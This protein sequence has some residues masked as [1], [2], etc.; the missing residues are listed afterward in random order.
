ME[1]SFL[2]Y[3]FMPSNPEG[4]VFTVELCIEKGAENQEIWFPNW[5]PGSYKIR[6]FSKHII[7]VS[8]TANAKAVKLKQLSKSVWRVESPPAKLVVTAK[9]YGWDISVRGCH[10]DQTHGFFNGTHAF[11]AVKGQ[12]NAPCTVEIT[13]PEAKTYQDWTLATGM[14][15]VK[16]DKKG[17]GLY[18]AQNYDELIDHPFEMSELDV[19]DFKPEGIPHKLALTGQIEN[20]DR[21]KIASDLEKLCATQ[22]KLF[23]E[24]PSKNYVF[25]C[26]VMG[27]AF[28]GLEHRASSK[29]VISRKNIPYVGMPDDT[30]DYATF[31]S[32]VSHEYF[33]TWNVKRI[34]PEIFMP[35][36]L[37]SESYTRQLWI[38][39][40]FTSYYE[41]LLLVR[42]GVISPERF[43]SLFAYKM[44]SVLNGPGHLVQSVTDSSFCAWDKFYDPNENSPNAVVSY[45]SKGAIIAF[46]IDAYLRA[47]LD[48]SLDDVMRLLW[49]DFGKP[50]I[51]LPETWLEQY[52]DKITQGELTPALQQWL[53]EAKPLPIKEAAESL[54][55]SFSYVPKPDEVTV[56]F[57]IIL[58]GENNILV[59]YAGGAAQRAGLSAQDKLVAINGIAVASDKFDV[60]LRP[61]KPGETVKVHAFRRDELMEFDLK[62]NPK[63][64]SLVKLGFLEA[65]ANVTKRREAWLR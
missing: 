47:N 64:P 35:Y 28:N 25:L 29:L 41:D 31:L 40:G 38:F 43:F 4:H 55:V 1:K 11:F 32:L 37:E 48:T 58:D 63:K 62:L 53:Y 12:E 46:M 49:N 44:T 10:F 33:H 3:R 59:C 21:N 56:A 20:I 45:Y 14:T 50:N 22:I 65:D 23:G 16:I 61:Y 19:I 39:E 42:S 8:A 34:K 9:I 30:E 51:G 2:H 17:F 5:I 24:F 52:L 7:S 27:K 57:D 6:D 26:H 36:N 54:G 13:A 15:P 60:L 18:S